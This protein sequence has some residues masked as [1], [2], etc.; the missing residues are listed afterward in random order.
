MCHEL[1]VR[2]VAAEREE[3]RAL[4]GVSERNPLPNLSTQEGFGFHAP[5]CLRH[6]LGL[7]GMI[8]R[9]G[10]AVDMMHTYCKSREIHGCF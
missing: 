10:L 4:P 6:F 7:L 2:G 1:Y 5:D 3:L 8:V 9:D